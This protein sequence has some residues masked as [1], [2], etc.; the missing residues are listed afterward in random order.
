MC[1][2]HLRNC[3]EGSMAG[4]EQIRDRRVGDEVFGPLHRACR[5]L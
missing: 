5:V 4:V 3:M 2:T 1:L